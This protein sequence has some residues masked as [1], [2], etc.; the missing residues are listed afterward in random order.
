MFANILVADRTS[1]ADGSTRKEQVICWFLCSDS[2]KK[3]PRLAAAPWQTKF[4][5]EPG[6]FGLLGSFLV[7]L[8]GFLCHANLL[9]SFRRLLLGQ[10]KRMNRNPVR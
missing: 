10:A 8:L 7:G 4:G 9:P 6:L 2:D 5:N 1:A 3:A